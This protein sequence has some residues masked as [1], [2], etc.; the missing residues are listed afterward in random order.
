MMTRLINVGGHYRAIRGAG[1]DI[2]ITEIEI[3]LDTHSTTTTTTTTTT[4]TPTPP[5]PLHSRHLSLEG[6][7]SQIAST[8]GRDYL[9]WTFWSHVKCSLSHGSQQA[10][11]DSKPNS[12]THNQIYFCIDD[13]VTIFSWPEA[14]MIWA[15][16]GNSLFVSY[17][18]RHS[19][20]KWRVLAQDTS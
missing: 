11:P 8:T 5:T 18:L 13:T 10:L 15:N 14:F 1:A 2:I 19:L 17:L 16:I 12:H 6:Q 4:W 20:L 9:V 7:R 3:F